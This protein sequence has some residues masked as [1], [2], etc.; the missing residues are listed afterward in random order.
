MRTARADGIK[1][2][3]AGF[4]ARALEIL[5]ERIQ[6]L[7]E[8]VPIPGE[9]ILQRE[10]AALGDDVRSFVR[11]IRSDGP[12]SV[13]F[14]LT[15]GLG[16][17]D[18]VTIELEGGRLRLRGAID[19][20]DEDLAGLHVIDYKT[21]GAFG[22]GPDAFNGGRRLQHAVYARA[23]EQQLGVDVV[24]GQYHFPTRKGQNQTFTYDRLQL[25]GLEA[26]LDLLM[27][28]VAKGHFVPTDDPDDC[29]FC[30]FADICRVRRDAYGKTESPMADWSQEQV[31]FPLSPA[32]EQLKRVRAFEE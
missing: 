14:E 17:E 30:D 15:F 11:M 12:K 27:D 31:S 4:E 19:R 5:T 7:R 18:P 25:S 9:G 24:D 29:S 8:E 21:G 20:V 26:L 32:V 10:T 28:G 16:E 23:A 1:P 3:E 13:A 22:Y 6:V 2:D